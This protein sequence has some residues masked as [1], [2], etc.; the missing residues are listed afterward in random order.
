M[1]SYK[2]AL[3]DAKSD[4]KRLDYEGTDAAEERFQL[5][6][7]IEMAKSRDKLYLEDGISEADIDLTIKELGLES[8]LEFT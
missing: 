3:K 4:P 1:S 7:H 6:V 2:A 5:S 8:D